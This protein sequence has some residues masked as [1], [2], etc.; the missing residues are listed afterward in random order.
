L[1]VVRYDLARVTDDLVYVT[2]NLE[3]VRYVLARV[4]DDLVDVTDNLIA[5]TDDFALVR[6]DFARVTD[7]FSLVRDDF[8]AVKYLIMP[9]INLNAVV[10]YL[11][12]LVI[13]DL[14]IV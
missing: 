10:R 13:D 7:D 9:S 1:R 11:L 5:V 14:S 3:D 2:D 12:A 4:T 6:D 8:A